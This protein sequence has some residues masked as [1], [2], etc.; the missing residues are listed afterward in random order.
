MTRSRGSDAGLL[1]AW[2]AACAAGEILG[3]ATAGALGFGFSRM[4]VPSAEWLDTLLGLVAVLLASV[5][6]PATLA[7][8]QGWVLRRRLPGLSPA[9]FA[10]AAA[11]AVAALF[12]LSTLL[13]VTEAGASPPPD[14]S[15]PPAAPEGASPPPLDVLLP[16]LLSAAVLPAVTGAAIA[17]SQARWVLRPRVRRAWP[18]IAATALAWA[19]AR[20][21]AALGLAFVPPSIPPTGAILVQLGAG[22][23]VGLAIGAITWPA[24]R[25]LNPRAEDA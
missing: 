18:W 9:A 17:A 19:V 6:P 15:A 8:A 21:L 2:L 14:P 22:A 4:P 13:T 20:P 23:V 16:M 25:R 7:A 10:A 5:A 1:G 3:G 12:V 11:V 24:V